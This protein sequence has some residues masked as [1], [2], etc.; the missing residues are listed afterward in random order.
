LVGSRS[1]VGGDTGG[2]GPF[3][4]LFDLIILATA[5]AYGTVW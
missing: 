5:A 2:G 1:G 4:D 3:E